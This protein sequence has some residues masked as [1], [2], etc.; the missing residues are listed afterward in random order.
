MSGAPRAAPPPRHVSE[1]LKVGDH[2]RVEGPFGPSYLRET[3]RGP[4]IA[5]AGG[6][7]MAPIKSMVER[8]LQK[9]LPQH[10]YFYFGVR[11]ERDLYLHDHFARLAET[12]KNLHFIPVLSEG[13]SEARRH[14]PGARGRRRR[15]STSSTAARPTSPAR[16]SWSR[17]RRSCSSSAACGASISM[18]TRSTPQPKWP[19]RARRRERNYDGHFSKDVLPSSPAPAAASAAPSPNRWSPRAP[20]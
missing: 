3:H 18:P 20:A 9:A 8:A 4:I 19:M 6:S 14:G 15:T 16:R 12:H 1:K 11:S 5:V 17:R 13:D 2:V 7:G 10:I